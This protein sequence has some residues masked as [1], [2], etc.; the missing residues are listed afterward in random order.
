MQGSVATTNDLPGS[1]SQGDAYIVQADDSLHIYDGSA[2]VSGG[3]IQGP[4]GDKGATGA[5]GPQGTQ[6]G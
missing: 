1:A 5:Q 6:G 4:Q 3:S 2:F